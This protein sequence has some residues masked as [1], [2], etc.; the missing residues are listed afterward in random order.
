MALTREQVIADFKI[1]ILPQLK[2]IVGEG[3]MSMEDYK[4][5]FELHLD[6]HLKDNTITESQRNKWKLKEI[7]LI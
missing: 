5:Y 6:G 4:M 3:N 7:D 2:K 1:N